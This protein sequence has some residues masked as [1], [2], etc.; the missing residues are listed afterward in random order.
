MFIKPCLTPVDRQKAFKKKKEK[1][2]N[3][4]SIANYGDTNPHYFLGNF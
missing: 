1:K 2:K 3:F 4:I